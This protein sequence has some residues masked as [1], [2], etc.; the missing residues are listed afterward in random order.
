MK[1]WKIKDIFRKKR[2][3][4]Q[5]LISLPF[6]IFLAVISFI[7]PESIT[8][9]LGSQNT[10]FAMFFIALLGGASIFSSIPYPL[11]LI[12]F[13]LGWENPFILASITAIAVMMGDSLSYILGKKWKMFLSG[14]SEKIAEKILSLY[15]KKWIFVFLWLF[16]YGTFS[17]FP[18]DIITLTSGIKWY[19]YFKMIL[20]LTLWNII[21]CSAL[22]YFA[23]FFA[24]Y[25]S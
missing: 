3:Y 1:F 7:S 9:K 4:K 24:P 6:I 14:K 23:E 5:A 22:A 17:P 16:F 13:S 25:F 20:P 2:T 11:F 15:D 10:Y 8:T 12:T 19:P 21:F 18:N